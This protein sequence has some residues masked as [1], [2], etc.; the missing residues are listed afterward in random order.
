[1]RILGRSLVG[2][3]VLIL[4]GAG[5]AVAAEPGTPVG[6]DP[7]AVSGTLECPT[8][9]AA[10]DAA[11]DTTVNVHHWSASDPRLGGEAIYRGQWRLYDG[12]AEDGGVPAAQQTA[13]YS[14]VNEGGSWLCEETR[15]P[16]PPRSEGD[17][18]T[19]VFT[20]QGEYEGLTA[21]LEVDL[22][23]APY[24]FSGLILPGDEPPW[25][26]PQG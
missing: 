4:V 26:E 8:D 13:V 15:T 19:L 22:T 23:Q 16:Q 6:S 24:V 2:A 10:S 11:T 7:V 17:R 9:A 18:Q 5:G 1:M 3:A 25:A 20:G 21:Y 12:P 14:I